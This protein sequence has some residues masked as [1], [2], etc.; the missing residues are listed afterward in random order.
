[1]K[2]ADIIL[3][4]P[5]YST[6]TYSIPEEYE[7]QLRIGFR[8]LVQFG[9]KKFYTGIVSIIHGN[10]PEFEVKPII[11]VLDTY[12]IIKHPQLQ[13]WEWI[14]RYYLCS[15]GDVY[16]AGVPAGIKLESETYVKANRDFIDIDNSMSEREKVVYALLYEKEK[17]TPAEIS[18]A[19]GYKSVEATI[20]KMIER[21]AVIVSERII[22]NYRPKT[23]IYVGMN[24]NHGED[25]K[26]KGF[27]DL[28]SR[29]KKREA[30]LLAYLDMSR[31]MSKSEPIEVTKEALLK[32]ADCTSLI[33]NKMVELGIFY[34]YTKEVNRFGVDE[35]APLIPSN[36]LSEVQQKAYREIHAAFKE[37]D[38]ALLHGVTSSG[39]T[40]IYTHLI[41]N[42]LDNGKQVLYL[43]PEIALTTQLTQ[44][45]QKVFGTKLLIYHSKFSDNERVDIWKRVLTDN[46]P[47]VVIGV[48]S[49]VF[50]P[51]GN[52]GLVIVDEEHETSYKQQDP[53]PR[54]N[55]RD[56]AL[57]L[58]T[59]HGAKTLLGS[60]TP[61]ITTY[62]HATTG[63]YALIELKTRHEG[64]QMPEVRTIDTTR[65]RKRKE[66]QG[67]FSNE[68][69]AQIKEALGRGEQ[70]ILFQNRRGYAP[71]IRCKECA[72]TPK[73]ENCD[74]TLTYHKRQ[75]A[76]VCHYCGYTIPLPN[77]CPVCRQP[78]LEIV[79]Y[80]TERIEDDVE[81]A[82][83]DAKISRMDLDT[84]R[85]KV[86][87]ETIIDNFSQ[88]KT[89]ILVGTQM[90]TKG[91]DFEGV[92]I[93]GILNADT[94]INFPDFRS[95]E[96]AFNMLEQVS[97]RAGRKHKQ[98]IVYI[99]TTEPEHSIINHVKAHDYNAYYTEELEE[100]EHFNYPPFTRIINI[101]IKH[102]DDNILTDIAV[103]YSNVLRQ[104]FGKRV[105][106]PETP[107]INRIQQMYIRQI[108]LKMETSASMQKVKDIL[109]TIYEN[110][111]ADPRMKSAIIYYDVDP[112]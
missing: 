68:L 64:I 52:L 26:V 6:F 60:A 31:W 72:W 22:D 21:E 19:T 44:R 81:K 50:L 77:M 83:P 15:V 65:A 66:M 102:R 32:R 96:R 35:N 99:Q 70:A 103:A 55:A 69:I 78:A 67:L 59:M 57:V 80:G 9:R 75:N 93:V 110:S 85:S 36:P 3:P 104:V 20:M 4:L 62:Y 47:Y 82:F 11:S 2:Y 1:M 73:C 8:V 101:F 90:V 54:Y 58:A 5:L 43:V 30:M 13:F 89:Q 28:V 16:K 23:I 12:P 37:K 63:K 38:I 84:T 46:S 112:A 107:G 109:R 7:S 56:A 29:A 94:M 42:A 34:Q 39:K 25:E 100:R 17:L 14:S 106:G 86:S 18:K 97:G 74:V 61:S 27:F 108:T 45:L 40:E 87:Y 24:A 88:G 76:L 51:F 41:Q 10:K 92:S 95:H 71:V 105:M 48:R 49:S 79:G 33:F 53:A 91:L 98:G 111:L